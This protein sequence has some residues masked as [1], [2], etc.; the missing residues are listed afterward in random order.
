MRT[1]SQAAGAVA[2]RYD[3]QSL[4]AAKVPDRPVL[5]EAAMAPSLGGHAGL[6]PLLKRIA[7]AAIRAVTSLLILP[8]QRRF[9]RPAHLCRGTVLGGVR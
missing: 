6:M 5:A 9:R 1:L 8:L 7:L 2:T 3:R 4:L